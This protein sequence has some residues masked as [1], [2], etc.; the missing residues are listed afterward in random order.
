MAQEVYVKISGTWREA[1]EVSVR[2]SGTW[3]N[4]AKVWARISGVWRESGPVYQQTTAWTSN[5]SQSYRSNLNQRS[6]SWLY[7]GYWD[8]TYGEQ[9][10][11]I[12]W[13]DA[14]MRSVLSGRTIESTKLTI[15]W[16]HWY[17]GGGGT[18]RYGSHNASATPATWSQNYAYSAYS[19]HSVQ[20]YR[21]T[22]Q[23]I[24][25]DNVLANYI[26]DNINKG[27][28]I[29][30]GNTSLTYYGYAHGHTSGTQKPV[31]TITHNV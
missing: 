10:S 25:M 11:M 26:R 21:T 13:D 27:V 4:T 3:R 9:R 22:T 7:Q 6:T 20:S 18:S 28:T 1:K 8:G 16:E 31:L 14:N 29:Y 12:F 5:A 19:G 15:R 17:Y 2:V 24:T 30:A 23:T